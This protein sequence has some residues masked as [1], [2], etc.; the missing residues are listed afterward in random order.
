M[1]LLLV[2]TNEMHFLTI[3]LG[4]VLAGRFETRLEEGIVLTGYIPPGI[5]GKVGIVQRFSSVLSKL[6]Q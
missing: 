2:E 1:H 3:K 4:M 6:P 5:A